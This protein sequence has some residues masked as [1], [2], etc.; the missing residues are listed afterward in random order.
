MDGRNYRPKQVELTEI[1]K[2]PLL[3]H[4]VGYLYNCIRD[5]RSKTSHLP[6]RYFLALLWAHPILHISTIRVKALCLPY[7]HLMLRLFVFDA[8]APQCARSPSF[9]RF[10]DHIQR[11]TTV[12]RILLDKWSA[13]RRDLYLTTHNTHNRQTSMPPV[14]FEPTISA[15]E[16]LQTARPLGPAYFTLENNFWIFLT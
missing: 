7:V 3:L 16:R 4:L 1:I 2:K 14:G 8:T 10:L 13:C 6:I 5:A 9:T 12:G 15:G 11:R